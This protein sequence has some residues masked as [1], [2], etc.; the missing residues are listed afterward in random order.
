M[1]GGISQSNTGSP[2]QPPGKGQTIMTQCG[3]TGAVGATTTTLYTVTAG[4]TFYVNTLTFAAS[5][6]AASA[7]IYI[8]VQDDATELFKNICLLAELNTNS[9][10]KTTILSFPTPIKFSTSYKITTLTSAGTA[11]V[12]WSAVGWEQ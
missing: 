10:T 5:S 8:T 7:I 12:S 1:S 6:M 4:K 11:L 3:Q 9:A 2:Y